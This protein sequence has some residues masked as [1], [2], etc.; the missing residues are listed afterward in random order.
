MREVDPHT[1]YVVTK[2]VPR[3]KQQRPLPA[4]I[5]GD[6]GVTLVRVFAISG[7]EGLVRPGYDGLNERITGPPD[8][9][10]VGRPASASR[11]HKSAAWREAESNSAAWL[12]RNQVS[13]AD[14]SRPR[15]LAQR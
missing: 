5:A 11:S 8:S 9:A 1:G 6:V 4:G 7:C 15:L 13:S 3:G 12:S 2:Y 14:G 10:N